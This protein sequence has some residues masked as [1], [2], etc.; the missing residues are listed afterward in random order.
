VFG[1]SPIWTWIE[2]GQEL[3]DTPGW[4]GKAPL[5]LQGR[6]GQ[7][8]TQHTAFEFK[9]VHLAWDICFA[10]YAQYDYVSLLNVTG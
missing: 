4:Y 5:R 2:E 10:S 1:E 7:C 8:S 3:H 9:T 6:H